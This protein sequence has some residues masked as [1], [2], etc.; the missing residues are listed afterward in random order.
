MWFFFNVYFF[1]TYIFLAYFRCMKELSLEYFVSAHVADF[2]TNCKI[3]WVKLNISSCKNVYLASFYRPN[4]D[5]RESLSNLAESLNKLPKDNSHVW[6]AGDMNLPGFNWPSGSLKTNCPSPSQHR[7]F[8]EILADNSLVQVTDQPTREGNV[9]DLLAVNNPTLVNW[10]DVIPGISDHDIVYAELDIAPQKRTQTKRKIPIYSKAKWN[11]IEDEMRKTLKEIQN[12][13]IDVANEVNF[14]WDTFKSNLLR[15]V[16][17]FVPHRTS[18]TRDRP[19]W[20]TSEVK[21]LLQKR[22]RLFK[23]VKQNP[24]DK[25]K[26]KL[27]SLKRKITKATKEAYWSYTENLI[28]ETDSQSNKKLWTFIKH[29]KTD[30]INIAPLKVNDTVKDTPRE[31]AEALNKQF[32]SVFTED[33]PLD[34]HN[35]TPWQRD[36]QYPT[37]ADIEIREDGVYKLLN[38]LNVHKAMGPDQLHP[39][40][41]KQLASTLAP[42][43][44][45]IF[46]KSINSGKVPS[47]WKK[48][49]VSPIFKKGERY[50]PS[51]YRPVSL[52]CICSKLLEHIVTKH[53]LNHLEQHNILY[54]LQHGFRSKRST[55]TQLIAFTQDVIKSLKSGDQTDV[56]I[57]D[58]EKAFDKVSHWRLVIKLRNYGITGPLNKWVEDFLYQR[59]QRVVCNGEHSEWAPVLS[60]VP[61][62][63]VIGPLLF[64]I[65]INDLIEIIYCH[66]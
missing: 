45:I 66:V 53:F 29:K 60:G 31:K 13:N 27:R 63:S 33:N 34:F 47:D 14:L 10:V 18:T 1:L 3:I 46:Q 6:V 9:L 11:K 57:M 25:R 30:S 35:L 38:S 21:K 24:T 44:Q 37:I 54:N 51:N 41:L 19:P 48:A 58:F 56:I 64:L 15:A 52:T 4:V 5:D 36:L 17:Q 12:L 49:N 43:L 28:T 61:Q 22:N 32:S 26:E 40:V 23:K 7:L 39:R 55:E 16:Q 59:S 42:I 8:L 65:Y 62:G 20:I 50:K 2:D